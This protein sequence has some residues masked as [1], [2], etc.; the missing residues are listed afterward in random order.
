MVG[1]G[2][3]GVVTQGRLLRELIPSST[4][5]NVLETNDVVLY[6]ITPHLHLDDLKWQLA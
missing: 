6:E 3:A 2:G 4:A 1:F 5:V